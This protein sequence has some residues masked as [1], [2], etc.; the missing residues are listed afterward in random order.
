MPGP[1]T[2]PVYT[3]PDIPWRFMVAIGGDGEKKGIDCGGVTRPFATSAAGLPTF[4]D[5]KW[6]KDTEHLEEAY[7]VVAAD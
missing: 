3:A 6:V 5:L 1:P 7:E 4:N 2:W